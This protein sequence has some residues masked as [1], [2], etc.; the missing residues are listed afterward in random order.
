MSQHD[1]IFS[2]SIRHRIARH[3][4]FLFVCWIFYLITYYIPHCV[5]PSWN[6]EKF[7]ANTARL[8]VVKW[9][10]WRIFNSTISL[11]PVLTFAYAIIY[12]VLPRYIFNKKNSFITT[13]LLVAALM[14]ILIIQYYCSY[15]IAWNN[16]RINPARLI[17]GAD[18]RIRL[19][20]NDALFNYP[21]VA[22]FA[23]IIKMMKRG[24]LKQ[25]ETEHIAREKIKTELQILKGQ[26]HPHFLFNTLNN[27]YFF[28]LTFPN[29]AVE[30]LSTLTGILRYL[31]TDCVDHFVPLKKELDMIQDYVALEKIR[32]GDRL[33]MTIEIKGDYSDK[34]ISPLMLIPLVE[35][36]FKHGA[37]KM[38]E[39]PWVNLDIT[40]DGLTL[41]FLLSN[42]RPDVKVM[43]HRNRHIGLMNVKKRLQLLYP[44]MHELNVEE[45]T[46]SFQVFMKIGLE[47]TNVI[48]RDVKTETMEYAVA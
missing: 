44:D 45:G 31:V 32:Y 28:T 13:G 47:E 39:H 15:F 5:F 27:I 26:I 19:V 8:G 34:M 38:L 43:D 12:F 46:R 4:G 3:V 25:Q 35:N 36:S 14:T 41:S 18:V 6:T 21:I 9:L 29:K 48:E 22:G 37:S 24:W 40:V 2:N 10:W 16:A 23:V 33:N 20:V 7:A 17:G 11:I 30:M 1:F 42:S